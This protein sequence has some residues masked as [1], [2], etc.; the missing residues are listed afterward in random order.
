LTIHLAL[1]SQGKEDA[2][3]VMGKIDIVIEAVLHR[4]CV[5]KL[6]FRQIFRMA[7]AKT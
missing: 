4:Q 1:A 6:R 5:G 3:D 7:M 2:K